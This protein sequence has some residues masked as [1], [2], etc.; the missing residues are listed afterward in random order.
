MTVRE[1]VERTLYEHSVRSQ[2]S[3]SHRTLF[4]LFS[5]VEKA[6]VNSVNEKYKYYKNCQKITYINANEKGSGQKLLS[7]INDNSKE[8]II[9]SYEIIPLTHHTLFFILAFSCLILSY[10]LTEFNFKKLKLLLT[11][12]IILVLFVSCSN[13]KTEILKGSVRWNQGKFSDSVENY[14]KALEKAKKENNQK[15]KDIA[16]YNLGTAYMMMGEFDSALDK[17]ME[18]SKDAEDSLLF[19]VYYNA[20]VIE[21]DKDNFESARVFFKKALE[22]DS[23]RIDAKINFELSRNFESAKTPQK[24]GQSFEA[25]LDSTNDNEMADKIFEHIKENEKKQWKSNEETPQG[26]LT[27]DY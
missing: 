18:I 17:Y 26:N 3:Y 5:N 16:L 20:G 13:S 6:S 1:D 25:S 4:R 27:E 12:S 22:I 24:D 14:Y 11:S 8:N 9:T 7:Q 21:Y 19:S 2:F 23:S 15:E 10:L